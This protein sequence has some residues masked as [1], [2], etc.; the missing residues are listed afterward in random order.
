MNGSVSSGR[1]DQIGQRGTRLLIVFVLIGAVVSLSLGVYGRVHAP[2]GRAITTLGFPTVIDMKVALSTAALALGAVQ[3]ITALRMFGRIGHGSP[4]P[5][6]ATLHRICGVTAVVVSAPVAFH[7]LWSLGFGTYNTRVVVHSV[8]GCVFYG[9]FVTKMLTLRSS[10]IPGWALPWLGG[11]LF[12]SLTA[13]WLTSSLWFFTRGSAP[14][15][16]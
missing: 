2:T 8:M 11:L 15:G 13:V 7:C 14:Y 3:V 12:A 5:A 1:P 16:S 10:R 9:I 6:T 4:G